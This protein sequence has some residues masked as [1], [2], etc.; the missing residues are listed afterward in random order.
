MKH[1]GII[2]IKMEII[3]IFKITFLSGFMDE[4]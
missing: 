3:M 1:V 4:I 2:P